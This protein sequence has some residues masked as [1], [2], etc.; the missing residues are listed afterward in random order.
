[1]ENKAIRVLYM[2]EIF[3]GMARGS[4]LVCIGW[5]TL[6]ISD[7]VATVG[8]IFMV[9]SIT[10]VLAGPL[11]GV[12]I[13]RH[14]RKQLIVLAQILLA[15]PIA[16]VGFILLNTWSIPVWG[17]FFIAVVVNFFRLMY[18]GAFDGL[19]RFYVEDS[20]MLTT[21]ARARGI[22]LFSAAL[23]TII[24]GLIIEHFSP[25]QAF[26]ACAL[27]SICLILVAG[28]VPDGIVKANSQGFG[29]FWMDLKG[30][31]KDFSK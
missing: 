19:L 17:L 11:I 28:Q 10:N 1:M 30:G 7:S 20:N 5:T 9:A 21:V 24:I 8:Q 12:L 25:G 23:G 18:Q 26:I 4:Y 6:V 31:L 2:F 27:I 22:H 29:G 14:K 13:D 3:S 15:L 16:S